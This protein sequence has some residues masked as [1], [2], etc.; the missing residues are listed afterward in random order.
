LRI[1][2]GLLFDR[3]DR[4]LGCY[5]RPSGFPRPGSKAES[6][7]RRALTGFGEKLDAPFAVLE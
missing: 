1:S 4:Y 5:G 3:I 2:G 7:T 6:L